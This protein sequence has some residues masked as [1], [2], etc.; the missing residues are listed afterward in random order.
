MALVVHRLQDVSSRE[1][2]E[3]WGL[4]CSAF[5]L[6]ERRDASLHAAA[7]AQAP[8]F[9]CLHLSDAAGF[10]GLLFYWLFPH[11]V[12]IEHLAIAE[13]RRGQ[14]WGSRVL[15]LVRQH[16][17]P[18]M[19]EIE[20]VCDAVTARRLAFYE[21]SGYHR[22]SYEHYQ[23]PYRRTEVPLRLELL[24]YPIA[25]DAGLLALFLAA[26]AAGPMRYRELSCCAE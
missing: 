9:V 3:A 16:T 22:L 20:P 1:F 8:D 6:A 11:C 13:A 24:S 21:R 2:A 14:G 17:L 4:Y 25:A 5:P 7:M 23:L 12:Y 26:Y 10:I 19:L 18:V 15:A